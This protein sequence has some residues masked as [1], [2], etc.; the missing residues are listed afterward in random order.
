MFTSFLSVICS[1]TLF[2][3][4]LVWLVS[5]QKLE[6]VKTRFEKA[7]E[8]KN[9]SVLSR[10]S[11][12]P[13]IETQT[14]SLFPVCDERAT[15]STGSKRISRSYTAAYNKELCSFCQTHD[16]KQPVHAILFES[17][18]KQL[19]HFVKNCNNDLYKV[20]L[21]RAINPEDALSI[22]IQYH[23]TCWTKYIVHTQEAKINRRKMTLTKI[24]LLQT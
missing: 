15:V 14:C 7:T 18:G 19:S 3:C 1:T 16:E 23:C 5:S 24:R 11:G 17:R 12:Q 13:S 10:T 9:S 4:I 22:D 21:S 8:S 20:F 2:L 6:R